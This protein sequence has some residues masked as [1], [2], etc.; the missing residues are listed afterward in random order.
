[1]EVITDTRVPCLH[2]Q[3]TD[4]FVPVYS[5]SSHKKE[6]WVTLVEK[7]YAKALGSYEA[8]S[9][10]RVS[11]LLMH[12]TGGSVQE[13][14]FHE[15]GGLSSEARLQFSKKLKKMISAGTLIVAKPTDNHEAAANQASGGGEE[16]QHHDLEGL[17]PD[18]YYNVLALKEVNISELVLLHC[19]WC[20]GEDGLDWEGD[21]SDG[22][23]KWDEYPEVL[24]GVQ[25]DPAVQWRR[26]DP[27]GFMWMSFKDFVRLFQGVHCCQLFQTRSR[28]S[29]RGEEV[30][31]SVSAHYYFD[32]GD[33]KDRRAGGPMVSI[34][35]RDE[36][37]RSALKVEH[38]SVLKVRR[39]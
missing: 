2:H 11:D 10:V 37:V 35:D 15:D 12:L 19:S 26:N 17:V 16:A 8:I 9:K 22:S 25:D 3:S 4:K 38:D 24:Q 29:C 6:L 27:K 23:A 1:V 7:A 14:R 18:K 36:G 33:F 32:K 5:R 31:S 21:W 13:V 30:D 34:R 39:D 20:T 28:T